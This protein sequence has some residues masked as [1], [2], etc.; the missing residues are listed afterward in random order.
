MIIT[1]FSAFRL[2]FLMAGCLMVS[3]ATQETWIRPF[4][5]EE[6]LLSALSQAISE[7]DSEKLWEL[8]DH[9]NPV[10]SDNAWRALITAKTENVERFAN[11]VIKTDDPLAWYVF[12]FREPD[13]ATLETIKRNFKR[14][15]IGSAACTFF[16]RHGDKEILHFLLDDPARLQSDESCSKAA[17]GMLTRIESDAGTIDQIAAMLVAFDDETAIRNLLYGFWRSELNRPADDTAAYKILMEMMYQ[18]N[19]QEPQLVDEYL[20]RLLGTEAFNAAMYRRPQHHLETNVQ[21]AVEVAGALADFTADSIHR[22]H[23]LRLLNHPN[24]HVI[25]RTLESLKAIEGLD[26][27]W[28]TG[29]EQQ[30]TPLTE[31]PETALAY[32]ELLAAS[33]TDLSAKKEHLDWIYTN[34]PYLRD[35]TLTLYRPL[36]GENAFLALLENDMAEGGIEA[37]RATQQLAEII[38]ARPVSPDYVEVVRGVM[39]RAMEGQNRSVISVAGPLLQNEVFFGASDSTLFEET[40]RTA[41]ENGTVSIAGVMAET[42]RHHG[43]L[44]PVFEEEIPEQPIRLPNWHRLSEM[45]ESPLWKLETNRGDVLIELKPASAPF[46][47]SSIDELTRNGQCNGTTFHRVVRNFVIQGGDFDRRDG[48]GGPGY[49]LP[50][51]PSFESFVPGMAGIASSGPDTEG[52]QFFVTHTWTP[53]LDGLYTIFGEVIEGMDVVENIQIG[54]IVLQATIIIR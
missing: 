33:G 7:R 8:K 12:S 14:G 34:S 53:H 45:G 16:Y 49:R 44:S 47:V 39:I 31:N 2:F 24:A 25:R 21:F 11:D 42:A 30:I 28:V 23:V 18:R 17:G 48:F 54:D 46:T 29:L 20:V 4:D 13:D 6:D 1:Q 38:N 37:M 27:G 50:T 51:E 36:L 26:A 35:R 3:C 19:G 5:V 10:I 22:E 40:Y 15:E 9:E 43:I 32:L 52:S 41:A